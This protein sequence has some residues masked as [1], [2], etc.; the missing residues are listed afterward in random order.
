MSHS[1]LSP[2]YLLQA[3]YFILTS[4]S[5]PVPSSLGTYP[6]QHLDISFFYDNYPS[7]HLYT[8]PLLTYRHLAPLHL[9]IIRYKCNH[10]KYMNIIKLKYNSFYPTL[11]LQVVGPLTKS[12]PKWLAS[13]N[14]VIWSQTIPKCA[15][16][17]IVSLQERSKTYLNYWET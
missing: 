14:V 10:H 6:R 11:L 5:N 8:S 4:I 3:I 9:F 13:K 12:K 1:K 17:S 2:S 7:Q 16:W 15:V